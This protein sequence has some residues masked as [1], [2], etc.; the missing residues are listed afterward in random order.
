MAQK[1]TIF[2]PD[3]TPLRGD[4][5][6]K[7]GLPPTLAPS[8]LAARYAHYTVT[9]GVV[10]FGDGA[11]GARPPAGSSGHAGGVNVM[12]CDGS[13]RMFQPNQTDLAFL[14]SPAGRAPL[15]QIPQSG[16]GALFLDCQ[17]TPAHEID[18]FLRRLDLVLRSGGRAVERLTIGLHFTQL[19]PAAAQ[20]ATPNARTVPSQFRMLVLSPSPGDPN[21]RARS[22]AAAAAPAAGIG[23]YTSGFEKTFTVWN[24]CPAQFSSGGGTGAQGSVHTEK[25]TITYEHIEPS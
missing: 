18:T 24:V 8:I 2:L 25:M 1:Y 22:T 20:T 12:L 4:V 11:S 3:G 5:S 13:V 16:P 17:G 7:T 14:A 21:L 9:S 10:H 23:R 15:E 6:V 19:A